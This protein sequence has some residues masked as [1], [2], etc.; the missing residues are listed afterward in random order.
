MTEEA[1]E[2]G[3]NDTGSA[4]DESQ[5]TAEQPGQEQE[6]AASNE[7]EASESPSGEAEGDGAAAEVPESYEF[8]MP[9]GMEFD[10]GL[11]DAVAPVF[12][13]LGLTQDQ[14]SKLVDA[15]A[16]HQADQQSAMQEAMNKQIEGWQKELMKDADFGGD[17]FEENAA[18]VREFIDKTAPESVKG[19]L[20]EF[21][22]ETGI[23]SQPALVKYMH[24]LATKF[25]VAEDQPGN[26]EPAIGKG[27][28][29]S[30]WY[31]DTGDR[32]N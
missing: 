6:T 19:P 4:V 10:Q 29:A 30:R 21:L 14:A 15:Y 25:S 26:G 27:D 13:E 17:K 12:K 31:S 8:Q 7:Q 23:G 16:Q 24:H 5:T 18:A 1:I 3:Q 28:I 22:N 2:S 11:N 32:V 20:V 9:E